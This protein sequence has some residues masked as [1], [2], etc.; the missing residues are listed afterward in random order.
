MPS[1]E[2][3]GFPSKTRSTMHIGAK[4]F[5]ILMFVGKNTP[6]GCLNLFTIML[7]TL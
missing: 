6:C 5:K 3:K 7:S 4:D 1:R 2:Q